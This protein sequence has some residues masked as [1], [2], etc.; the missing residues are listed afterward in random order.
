MLK[1]DY[2]KSDFGPNSEN[3]YV[4]DERLFK[5][6]NDYLKGENE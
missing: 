6:L 3:Y 4:I 5:T 1:I 2:L